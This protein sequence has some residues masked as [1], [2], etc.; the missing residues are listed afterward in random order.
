MFI[1]TQPRIRNFVVLVISKLIVCLISDSVWQEIF[2]ITWG[3]IIYNFEHKGQ[4][5]VCSS[6]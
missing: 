2:K 1:R 4:F 6:L 5:F 3:L